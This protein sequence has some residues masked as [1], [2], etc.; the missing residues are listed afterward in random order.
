MSLQAAN[1]VT[2][3]VRLTS[4]QER[5]D[6]TQGQSDKRRYQGNSFIWFE[7]IILFYIDSLNNISRLFYINVHE[8]KNT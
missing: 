5:S 4:L 2:G 7:L 8:V 1:Q 3:D 6:Q